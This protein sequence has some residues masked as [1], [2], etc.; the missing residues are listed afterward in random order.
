MSLSSIAAQIRE[1]G[2]P[3]V[4]IFSTLTA[5]L[6]LC[7]PALFT[8]RADKPNLSG[9]WKLDRT[10]TE[11]DDSAKDLV[12]LI[13]EQDENVHLKETRGPNPKQ[14]VSEFTC[15]LGKECK[16][17]DGGGKAEVWVYFNGPALVVVKTNGR[18]DD[19][20][21]KRRFVLSP[22]GDSLI[23]EVTH[24]TP[25]RKAQKLVFSKSQ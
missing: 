25:E 6:L 3:I 4:R 19:S 24:I 12:L 10:H 9:T 20:A 11:S 14:D 23:E 16:M 22:A 15:G 2:D 13:D 5:G 8:A 21:S 18:H 7:T 1:L 17:Q